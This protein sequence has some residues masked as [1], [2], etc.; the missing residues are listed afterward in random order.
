MFL[1][2]ALSLQKNNSMT[3][4]LNSV[5]L[6]SIAAFLT[7]GFVV[8]NAEVEYSEIQSESI[9]EGLNIGN[10]AP[11]LEYNDPNGKPIALSSLKGKV[12]LI[13]FW[14]SWCGPCRME[15]PNVVRTYEKYRDEKFKNGKGFTIYGVSL[16]VDKNK[17]QNAIVRDK[18]N[19]ESH[20][21]DLKGWGSEAGKKYRVRG[22]P[23]NF[24]I[25]GDGIIVAKNLRGPALDNALQKLLK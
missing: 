11:A 16:D 10:K 4:F 21:S 5:F 19:W 23:T 1:K 24:L 25:D 22:I 13:D 17:W 3:R 8:S 2:T 18:L 12:V 20:V 14:A 9:V 15:N 7:Y 6:L